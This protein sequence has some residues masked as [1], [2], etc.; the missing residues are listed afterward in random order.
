[1]ASAHEGQKLQNRFGVGAT[2]VMDEGVARRIVR[3]DCV[4]RDIEQVEQ[5]RDHDARAVASGRAV[6]DEGVRCATREFRHDRRESGRAIL[7]HLQVAAGG[8]P[9]RLIGRR[10]PTGASCLEQ[11]AMDMLTR[12]KPELV[13]ARVELSAGSQ[14]DRRSKAN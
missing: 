7:Q 1:M 3:G 5:T 10:D 9:G 6:D 11:R 2:A 13:V 8:G 12:R 4:I 14:V